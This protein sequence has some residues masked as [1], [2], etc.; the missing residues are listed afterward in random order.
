MISKHLL[1]Q[2]TVQNYYLVTYSFETI[3][4]HT[5]FNLTCKARLKINQQLL[6]FLLFQK[7]DSPYFVANLYQFCVSR[8]FAWCL[9]SH[10]SP[11]HQ[12]GALLT[13]S[14]LQ[15]SRSVFRY[16]ASAGV[17]GLSTQML[18]SKRF[19]KVVIK[20]QYFAIKVR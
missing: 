18:I 3:A 7:I 8:E 17:N 14:P 16:A 20:S 19:T 11:T 4:Y 13:Y 5:F 9:F 6:N 1:H 2:S 12:H 10:G 15:K